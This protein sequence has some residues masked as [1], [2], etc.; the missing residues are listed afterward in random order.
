MLQSC[1]QLP[2]YKYSTGKKIN[3]K[4]FVG[5]VK[6]FAGWEKYQGWLRE[7]CPEACI[8]DG[9]V[10]GSTLVSLFRVSCV[11]QLISSA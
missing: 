5:K 3:K 4:S 6:R 7:K 8:K 2:H 11:L 9:W 1:T 10:E